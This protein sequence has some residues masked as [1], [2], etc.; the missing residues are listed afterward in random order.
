MLEACHMNRKSRLHFVEIKLRQA[1]IEVVPP[2]VTCS[3][4]SEELRRR[5]VQGAVKQ[6][7]H[8]DEENMEVVGLHRGTFEFVETCWI[9]QTSVIFH[10]SLYK[11][12]QSFNQSECHF[13]YFKLIS[14]SFR[15]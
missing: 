7:V 12:L 15:T 6:L 1:D 8:R 5:Q 3:W 13:V 4:C 2:Q 11:R 10:L 9:R 14:S